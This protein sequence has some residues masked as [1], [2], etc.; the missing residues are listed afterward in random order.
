LFCYSERAQVTAQ[1]IQKPQQKRSEASLEKILNAARILIS[2]GGFDEASIADIVDAAGL[3]VGAFYARFKDKDALFH[4]IQIQTL[5]DLQALITNRIRKFEYAR[6]KAGDETSL[7][8]VAQF[9]VDTLFE[10]YSH[11][12]GLIRAIY[13][14][15]R[16]K[17][18]AVLFE[19]VKSFNAACIE[20]SRT[21]IDLLSPPQYS[22]KTYNA[23]AG[24]VA[25]VGA[26]L[27]EQ[28]L[29]GDPMPTTTKL[30]T[31]KARKITTQMLVAFMSVH[32]ELKK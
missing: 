14:H 28:M 7:D 27:R 3:S 2:Q 12:P 9:A 8:Q 11:S 13:T 1:I 10:L 19:R 4:I 20:Q 17:R 26:F 18:D 22:A 5:N 31:S 23:W 32:L 24:A 25:V 30:Q 21:L 16:V 6:R 29:F 15:T